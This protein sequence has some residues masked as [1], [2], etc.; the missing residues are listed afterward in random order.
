ME[1]QALELAC[2]AVSLVPG[3]KGYVGVDLVLTDNGVQLI[4]INPRLTTSYIGLRQVVRTNL[5]QAIWDA[6]LNDQLP[7]HIELDG[8]VVIRKDDPASWGK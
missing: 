4:E 8:Q 7:D 6:C 3:L 1:G 2:A 5:A